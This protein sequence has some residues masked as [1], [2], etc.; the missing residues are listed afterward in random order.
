MPPIVLL[1]NQL[2]LSNGQTVVLSTSNLQASEAG[3]NESQLTFTVGNV[4]NGYFATVPTGSSAS[5]N[6]TSFTQG[7]VQSGAIEFVHDG[8]DQAPGY[9]VLV[10][11]GTQSTLPSVA[12][13]DFAGAP[14]ITRNQLNITVGGI[15]TLTPALLNV[16]ITDGSTPDQVVLTISNLQRA[17]VTSTV[18]GQ[19]VNSFTLTDLQAGK[20]QLTQDGSLI[21]PSYTLVAQ[22][23][24]GQTSAPSQVQVYFSNQGV[25]APQL[26]N[27][28]LTVT[29]GQ[30]TML[31]SRYLSAQ[32]SFTGQALNNL[33]MFYVSNL[34]YGH[35][36]LTSQP[37]TWMSAFS[38]Q[39]LL[40][41]QVQFVQD[42]S[43]WVPGYQIEVETSNL[44]SANEPASIFFTPVGQP[45]PSSGG[46][47]GYTSIQKA[48]IS[49]VVSGTIGLF[50]AILQICL[51]RAA[52]KKLLQALGEGT[53]NYD[54]TVVRPVATEI[55]RHIKVTGFMNHARIRK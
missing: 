7:Q 35:F 55:A 24:T 28:Y 8:H 5:K 27:N 14:I 15:V 12:M 10:S 23:A 34:E 1:E 52:D 38:Q 22:G 42:G 53:D 45:T 30:A 20:I 29:Q 48:I 54:L 50:F 43:S 31:S 44:F 2:T 13:I 9:S 26:V 40:E 39:Q 17:T 18:T 47:S 49:S 33:T 16:T 37:Q 4:Q 19:P 6:L 3:F 46:D 41:G 25:Y 36:S 11:D 51:K 21:T 32:Q